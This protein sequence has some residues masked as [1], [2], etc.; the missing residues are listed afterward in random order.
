[1][2]S[3]LEIHVA[4]SMGKVDFLAGQVHVHVTLD[5]HLPNGQGFLDKLSSH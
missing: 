2:T 5:T 4:P 3:G 1:M